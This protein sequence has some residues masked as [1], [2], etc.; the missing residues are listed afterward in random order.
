M[1]DI[2]KKC[3]YCRYFEK[4]Y[5]TDGDDIYIGRCHRYPKSVDH[6]STYWCGEWAAAYGL[7]E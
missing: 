7:V 6:M 4:L 5:F 2:D 3:K 1:R